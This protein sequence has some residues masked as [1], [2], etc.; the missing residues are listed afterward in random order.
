MSTMKSSEKGQIV[1]LLMLVM[2]VLLAFTALAIDG[3]MVY[4]DRRYAQSVADSASLAG[5]G[6]AANFLSQRNSNDELIYIDQN[7][8]SMNSMIAQTYAEAINRASL[9]NIVVTQVNDINTTHGVYVDCT[10]SPNYLDV[11]VRL[12]GQTD[13]AFAHLVFKDQLVYTVESITRVYAAVTPGFGNTI[14]SLSPDCGTNQ[15]GIEFDGSNVTRINEGGIHSNS[16]LIK[17]GTSGW[18]EVQSGAITYGTT[19]NAHMQDPAKVSPLPTQAPA[20]DPWEWMDRT[21]AELEQR[22][23]TEF[24]STG[25]GSF[26]HPINH[27]GDSGVDGLAPGNY[28]RMRL[29]SENHQLLLQPGLYC[30]HTELTVNGDIFEDI[31]KDG[32][33]GVTIYLLNG[34]DVSIAGSVTVNL[35]APQGEDNEVYGSMAGVLFFM[36]SSYAG[37]LSI[38]G[39]STSNI[40]GGIYAPKAMVSV[41]GTSDLNGVYNIQVVGWDV[42]IHGGAGLTVNYNPDLMPHTAPRLSLL[43]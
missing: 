41:G 13:T 5:S 21:S 8:C 34:A 17:N 24:G 33:K 15:G 14:V 6:T 12:T 23:R 10:G 36:N 37:N 18:I 39:N 40:T 4:S 16:C 22:C 9:N 31:A 19:V 30:I 20:V 43:K 11:I 26:N 35:S 28:S 1:I 32:K 25:Q 29:N 3:G 42:K 27:Q 2:L 7:L 38:N